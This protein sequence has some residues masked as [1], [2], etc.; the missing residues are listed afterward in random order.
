MIKVEMA[1]D[2]QLQMWNFLA[3]DLENVLPI[4]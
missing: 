3:F 2:I 4:R 1:K